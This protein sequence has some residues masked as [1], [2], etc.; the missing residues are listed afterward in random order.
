MDYTKEDFK[1]LWPNGYQ[2]NF[3][4]E[5]YQYRAQIETCLDKYIDHAGV[6]L[7]IGCGSGF[8][9]AEFLL[10]RFK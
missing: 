10:K 2:E 5:N 1:N 8:W 9:T 6:A 7:D 4:A 3:D